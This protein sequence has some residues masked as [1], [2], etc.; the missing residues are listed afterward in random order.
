M[1]GKR[2]KKPTKE[3]EINVSGKRHKSLTS[4][5]EGS[6]DDEPSVGKPMSQSEANAL[7]AEEKQGREEKAG[8]NKIKDL[9]YYKDRAQVIQATGAGIKK[10]GKEFS[11]ELDSKIDK[12]SEFTEKERIKYKK[13]AEDYFNQIKKNREKGE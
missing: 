8:H 12:L 9:Q 6:E 5:P 13:A 11:F 7:I 1:P 10:E 2:T 3:K 4:S